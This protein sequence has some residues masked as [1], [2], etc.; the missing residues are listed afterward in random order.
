MQ[1]ESICSEIPVLHF[2]SLE[3]LMAIIKG[4]RSQFLPHAAYIV[5]FLKQYMKRCALPEL[6]TKVYSTIRALLISMG[7]G[8]LVLE[9]FLQLVLVLRFV[10]S[11]VLYFL[12][13]GNIIQV[14]SI[15]M[16]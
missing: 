16:A 12:L 1:Q 8:K 10:Y 9:Y 4:M 3:L 6:R 11:I 13:D 5:R 14:S 7:V 2:Y 15:I